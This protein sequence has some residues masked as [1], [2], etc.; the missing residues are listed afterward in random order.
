M[1]QMSLREG[2]NKI[3]KADCV[4]LMG[5]LYNGQRRA[6]TLSPDMQCVLCSDVIIPST[7][8]DGSTPLLS[9]P[10]LCTILFT[11][12]SWGRR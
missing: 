11:N 7:I 5:R 1:P 9:P 8:K 12:G 3:L 10:S 4:D 6:T 2:C